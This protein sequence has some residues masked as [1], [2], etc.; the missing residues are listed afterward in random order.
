MMSSGLDESITAE[1]IVGLEIDDEDTVDCSGGIVTKSYVMLSL[2]GYTVVW[3]RVMNDGDKITEM[4]IIENNNEIINADD[5]FLE[6]TN[7]FFFF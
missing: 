2:S 3:A 1:K 7:I 6:L 4:R 5:R